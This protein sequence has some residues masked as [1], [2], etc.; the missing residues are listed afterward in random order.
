MQ[1]SGLENLI[2][3]FDTCGVAVPCRSGLGYQDQDAFDEAPDAAD[4]ECYDSDDDLDDAASRPAE[5]EIVNTGASQQN[6]EDASNN[7]GLLRGSRPLAGWWRLL[8]I[9]RLIAV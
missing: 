8:R 2:G 6:S 9:R 4:A 1:V 7:P 3:E 5:V